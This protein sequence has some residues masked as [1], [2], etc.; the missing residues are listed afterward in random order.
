M[1]VPEVLALTKEWLEDLR[2]AKV[3]GIAANDTDTPVAL[4]QR[5]EEAT[6]EL[7]G[8]TVHSKEGALTQLSAA[9]DSSMR[10]LRSKLENQFNDHQRLAYRLAAVFIHRGKLQG[11][12]YSKIPSSNCH[13]LKSKE[14]QPL[15]TTGSTFTISK[16]K[17]GGNTTIATLPKSRTKKR[18]LVTLRTNKAAATILRQH[19]ISWSTSKKR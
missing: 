5:A 17:S 18:S 3:D 15:V 11:K 12:T 4:K 14:R 1:S 8:E 9:I 2:T 10:D 16:K 19:H 7:E 13:I 6:K